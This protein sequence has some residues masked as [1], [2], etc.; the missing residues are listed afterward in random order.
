MPR[1]VYI[2]SIIILLAS[3]VA[4]AQDSVM[5]NNSSVSIE[6]M[7]DYGKGLESLISDQKKWEFGAGIIYKNKIS[8]N[9]E[10]G[11]AK[12]FPES[13]VMNGTYQVEGDYLRVGAEYLFTVGVNRYLS[14]GG[15]YASSNFDDYGT[16]QVLSELWPSL[17]E[18]FTRTGLTA[19]WAEIILNTQGPVFNTEQGF[20][21][22]FY[23]GIRF[24]LKLMLTDLDQQGF[25]IYAVPGFGKTY[26][27]ALPAVNLFIRYR[28]KL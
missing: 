12:L 9:A 17:N 26:S 16:V 15:M 18:E 7:V 6:L 14:V 1:R 5:V 24:R 4:T 22:G 27:K 19:Q 23:W 10:Y 21:S 3:M 2:T 25:D 8:L 11:Y 13:V 28:L 20:L